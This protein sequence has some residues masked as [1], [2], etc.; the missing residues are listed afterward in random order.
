MKGTRKD[1]ELRL[2]GR[3][4]CRQG[5]RKRGEGRTGGQRGKGDSGGAFKRSSEK[6]RPDRGGSPEKRK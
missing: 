5:V 3:G 1:V 4:C 6:V 2:E